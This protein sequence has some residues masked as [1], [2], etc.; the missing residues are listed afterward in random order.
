MK[1]S[2]FDIALIALALLLPLALAIWVGLDARTGEELR[3]AILLG[4]LALI[5]IG[6]WFAMPARPINLRAAVAAARARRWLP[7]VGLGIVISGGILMI[8]SGEVTHLERMLLALLVLLIA[9]FSLDRLAATSGQAA[10]PSRAGE[11][12]A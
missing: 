5:P 2:R 3:T 9:M 1:I 10:G 6:S 11:P 4:G 8:A 12:A 7:F